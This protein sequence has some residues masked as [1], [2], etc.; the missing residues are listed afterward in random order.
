MLDKF[1]LQQSTSNK[2]VIPIPKDQ[3]SFDR[4]K[5]MPLIYFITSSMSLLTL[6]TSISLV[7][8]NAVSPQ[9][10]LMRG[11]NYLQFTRRSCRRVQSKRL[12][13]CSERKVF[14]R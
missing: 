10:R 11:L 4:D 12:A 6:V 9:K 3:I 13:C 14:I 7:A 8:R 2:A 5:N 1:C